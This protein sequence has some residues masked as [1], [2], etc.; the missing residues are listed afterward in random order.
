MRAAL[1]LGSRTCFSFFTTDFEE[2]RV[3][4]SAK[5]CAEQER[6]WKGTGHKTTEHSTR[7]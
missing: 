7:T 1:S 5:E 6:N 2:K 3:C 4:I